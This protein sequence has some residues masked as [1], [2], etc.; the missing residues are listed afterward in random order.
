MTREADIGKGNKTDFTA[1]TNK[2]PPPN[3]Y[4]I[5]DFVT[6]NVRDGKGFNFGLSR[7][8]VKV[9][10]WQIASSGFPGVGKYEH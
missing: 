8:L 6:M 2:F 5:K 1:D 4:K 10:N 7:D 9:N 3:R